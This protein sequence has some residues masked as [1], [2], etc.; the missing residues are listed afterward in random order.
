M[1]QPTNSPQSNKHKNM[2]KY[3]R[4]ELDFWFGNWITR[5]AS[6][7]CLDK[8]ISTNVRNSITNS[9]ANTLISSFHFWTF[10]YEN[11]KRR[12]KKLTFENWKHFLFR[13]CRQKP[14]SCCS[15][16]LGL[17]KK[18][19][20]TEKKKKQSHWAMELIFK[21]LLSCF[22]WDLVWLCT[23]QDSAR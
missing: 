5:G 16:N 8:L 1:T 21:S 6:I 10:F 18:K 12:Q 22:C 3:S 14:E 17:C 20:K 4:A 2:L 23:C 9:L 13:V 11:V 15:C 7:S 19:N